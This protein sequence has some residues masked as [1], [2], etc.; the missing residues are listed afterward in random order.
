MSKIHYENQLAYLS[1]LRKETDNLILEMEKFA[2]EKNVPILNWNAS[3]FL[4]QLITIK[5]P[6]KVLEIGTAIGYSTIKIAK[7]LRTGCIV[8]TIELSKDNILIA[9][10]N[11]EKSGLSE[12]INLLEGNALNI[13]P[14]LKEKYDFIFL[15]VD[16]EDY[17]N[18]FYLSLELL[19]TDGV[20]FADNLLWQGY[21][22]SD[23]IN[24][25]KQFVNSTNHI[26]IF[27]KLFLYEES[28]KS[29]ILPIGDGLGL[30]IKK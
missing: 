25:P 15:D 6:K 13:M 8:D 24:V 9:K 28:L 22:A 21:A 27:N 10:N 5:N 11:F 2:K 12:K 20:F 4:E 26:R 30:G 3:D 23:D 1:K 29:S 19:K 18:L 17:E 7:N 14:K 16:K